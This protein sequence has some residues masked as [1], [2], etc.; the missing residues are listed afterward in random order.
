MESRNAGDAAADLVGKD[1]EH[2]EIRARLSRVAFAVGTDLQIAVGVE[3]ELV[4]IV[5]CEQ[6]LRDA[7]GFSLGVGTMF[8]L[9][10]QIGQKLV[11]MRDDIVPHGRSPSPPCATFVRE[12]ASMIFRSGM[13]STRAC[14]LGSCAGRTPSC[15]NGSAGTVVVDCG[16]RH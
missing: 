15:G 1:E 14:M 8:W 4:G 3:N 9:K 2:V 16:A 7:L 13:A 11:E 5:L 10:L 12:P 6:R